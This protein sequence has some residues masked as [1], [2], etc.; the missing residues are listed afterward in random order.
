MLEHQDT[1][2]VVTL[3]GGEPTIHPRIEEMLSAAIAA[4]AWGGKAC[5]AG[6]GGCVTVLTPPSRR[7]DVIA[8]LGGDGV[9]PARPT[10]EPLLVDHRPR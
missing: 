8:A 9:L 2:G 3:T 1:I 7:E 10:D 5:G 6:G 4:G